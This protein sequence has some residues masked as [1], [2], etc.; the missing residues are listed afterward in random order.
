MSNE[1]ECEVE[2]EFEGQMYVTVN[3]TNAKEAKAGTNAYDP[4][5]DEVRHGVHA[6]NVDPW[7]NLGD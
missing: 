6:F 2:M 7:G 4:S 1:K 5:A 3:A